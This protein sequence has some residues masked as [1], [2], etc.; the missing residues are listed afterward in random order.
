MATTNRLPLFLFAEEP[1]ERGTGRAVHRAVIASSILLVTG[2]AIVFT[3]LLAGNPLVLLANA[4]ASLVG[5]SERHEAAAQPIPAVQSGAEVQALPSIA[6][7]VPPGAKMA[8]TLETASEMEIQ[9]PQPEALLKGFQAW[10]AEEDARAQVQHVESVQ[11]LEPLGD[12]RAQDDIQNAGAEVRPA[13]RHRLVRPE[14]N[15][16]TQVRPVKNA[17]AQVQSENKA[18]QVRFR[19]ITRAMHN[20]QVQGPLEKPAQNTPARDRSVEN[21]RSMWPEGVFGWL[22]ETPRPPQCQAGSGPLWTGDIGSSMC[23]CC[24]VAY[25]RCVS[26]STQSV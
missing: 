15:V 13:Q 24:V 20:G 8:G 4:T 5:T 1:E 6:T 7:D 11:L 25:R 19:H 12:T 17:R 18:R 2:A 9:E 22:H 16:R 21:A 10:A 23:M 26:R 14:H 3:F